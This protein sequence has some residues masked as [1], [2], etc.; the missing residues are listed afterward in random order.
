VSGSQALLDEAEKKY[1]LADQKFQAKLLEVSEVQSEISN[2][3]GQIEKLE[4]KISRESSGYAFQRETLKNRQAKT[5]AELEVVDKQL[6][7]MAAGLLPFSLVPEL[8]D[9]LRNQLTVEAKIQQWQAS[10]ELLAPKIKQIQATIQGPEFWKNASLNGADHSLPDIAQQ[11]SQMI[12]GLLETDENVQDTPIIHQLADH[13]RYKIL[14]WIDESMTQVPPKMKELGNQ[15]TYLLDIQKD[16]KVKHHNV[17][18]DDVLRPLMEELNKLHQHLGELKARHTQLTQEK[19]SL[20]NDRNEAERQ[21][22]KA[23]DNQKTGKKIEERLVLVEKAQQALSAFL[24][25]ATKR[26]ITE[27]EKLVVFRFNQL[28][29]KADLVTRLEIDPQSF[30]IQLFDS[31]GIEVPKDLLSA[32]EKQMFAIA[33]LWALRDLSGK[34]FP[35]IIDTPLGRLDSDHRDHLVNQYFP[36]VSHQVILF[37]TD[38]EIDRSYFKALDPHVSRSYHLEYDSGSGSSSASLGYFWEGEKHVTQ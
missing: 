33:L 8:C 26:K 27:L 12:N 11:L 37:S 32:G 38:T 31:S 23:F 29:R 2:A 4:G 25:E 6:Q 16:L 13:D 28:I 1:K 19:G 17:P 24:V 30:H 21:L 7:E 34:P 18:D 35:V 36:N 15:L 5:Q 9:E 3:N 10:N 20:E 22:K 14:G